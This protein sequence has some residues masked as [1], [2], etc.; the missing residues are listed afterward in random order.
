MVLPQDKIAIAVL[1]KH[2]AVG[3]A[4]AIADNLKALLV[5]ASR[6]SEPKYGASAADIYRALSN[7]TR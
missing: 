4:S 2:E 5:G 1:T 7:W 6:R 3:A